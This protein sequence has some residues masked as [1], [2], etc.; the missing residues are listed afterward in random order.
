MPAESPTILRSELDQKVKDFEDMYSIINKIYYLPS[1][2]SI[3]ICS[4]YLRNYMAANPLIYVV[5]RE[6][7]TIYSF[8]YRGK[9]SMF[10]LKYLE[11]LLRDRGLPPTGFNPNV[12]PD[13]EWIKNVILHLQP[14]DRLNFKGRAY[15]GWGEDEPQ[16]PENERVQINPK[17]REVLM[18]EPVKS[19][20]KKRTALREPESKQMAKRA[21]LMKRSLQ[22]LKSNQNL[23]IK[24]VAETGIKQTKVLDK[25]SSL[26]E[27]VRE[28]EQREQ[29]LLFNRNLTTEEL[30]RQNM[31]QRV[32]GLRESMKIY[33]E[34]FLNSNPDPEILLKMTKAFAP[35]DVGREYVRRFRENRAPPQRMN[36]ERHHNDR[37]EEIF[38]P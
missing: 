29:Q 13:I 4:E 23:H 2:K 7:I 10:L 12:P 34:E 38:L 3:A 18:R 27:Q 20:K 19:D 25:I 31:E 16:V 24:Q 28:A 11:D 17:L 22:K 37:E 6:E 36:I 15:P 35:E 8:S 21:K 14:E 5:L 32:S 30:H 9:H 26:E 33:G 1:Q